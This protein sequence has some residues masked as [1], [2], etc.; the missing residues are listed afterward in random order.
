MGMEN[1]D[2]QKTVLLAEDE[3][4]IRKLVAMML[5]AKGYK[6]LLAES[7]EEA[8]KV[9]DAYPSPIDLL[10]TDIVM[11]AITGKELA[12]IICKVRK[13]TRVVFMSG[14][15]RDTVLESGVCHDKL[16]FLRK[17]FAMTEMIEMVTAVMAMN[18]EELR[19]AQHE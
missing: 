11:S 12:D 4:S 19:E 14:Y 7:G 18:P 5:E 3:S 15:P 16:F 2:L 8:L 1:T 9:S 13:E 6:V 17:P 10:L